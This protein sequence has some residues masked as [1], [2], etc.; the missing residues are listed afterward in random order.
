MARIQ[1]E[2]S[3]ESTFSDNNRKY[4]L[5][6]LMELEKVQNEKNVKVFLD[7]AEVRSPSE[8]FERKNEKIRFLVVRK[9]PP[10]RY[11]Y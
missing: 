11:K 5:Y 2:G 10:E 1:V 7:R 6:I 9:L 4:K 3:G 8:T